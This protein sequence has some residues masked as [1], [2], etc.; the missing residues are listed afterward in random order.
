MPLYRDPSGREPSPSAL[1]RIGGLVLIAVVVIGYLIVAW[2]GGKF[3]EKF[4]VTLV[5]NKV[6]DGLQS[7][8]DVRFRGLRIGKVV[9]VGIANDGQQRVVLNIEPAQASALTTDIVPVY[10]A[11]SIFTS[12]DIEFVPGADGAQTL[13]NNQTLHVRTDASLGTLTNVLGRAGKLTSTLGDPAVY[14]AL[15]GFSQNAD[16]YVNL[17]KEFLPIAADM[18]KAQTMP[19]ATLLSD[20]AEIIQAI[21]PIVIPAFS[22]IDMS[23]STTAYMAD[24]VKLKFT[25]D[26]VHGLSKNIVLSLGGMISKNNESLT[27]VIR[28]ALDLATPTVLSLASIPRAYDRLT[29]LLK[30]TSDAFTPGAD[31]RMRLNVELLMATA[32]Q[33]V[34]P[35]LVSTEVGRR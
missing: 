20:M 19:V 35:A 10:T 11:S 7:G 31:G 17:L 2:T 23:L 13:R 27:Q 22:V 5:S 3:A 34:A 8:T 9:T 1:A 30:G 4:T 18:T 25:T 15:Q 21:R 28:L 32:P 14:S 26:A 12:T 29:T 16:P 33:V 24:P 6:G